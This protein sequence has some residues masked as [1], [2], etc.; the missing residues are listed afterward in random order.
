LE[1]FEFQRRHKAWSDRTASKLKRQEM[2]FPQEM[3]QPEELQGQ[4]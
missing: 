2:D 4:Q 1:G 3:L